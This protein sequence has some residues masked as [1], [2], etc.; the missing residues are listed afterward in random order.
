MA[1]PPI[2][3]AQPLCLLA[4]DEVHVWRVALTAPAA[5]A[6]ALGHLLTPA[7]QARA[8]RF[9][10]EDDRCRFQ[11]ARAATRSILGA[12]L[13][14]PPQQVGIDLEPSGKPRLDA[15]SVPIERRVHFNISHSGSWILAAFATAFPVGID[16]EQVRAERVTEDLIG[17]I[18]SDS[19]QR[20][21][22]GLAPQ[23]RV[24]A[25]FNCWTSKEALLKG[26]GVGLSA[27]LRAIEVSID[28]HL[29][30]RLIDAPPEHG[31][32]EWQLGRVEIG[33]PYAATLAF[34]A[35]SA[36]IVNMSAVLPDRQR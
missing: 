2:R 18:M 12:Y 30:P 1:T 5:Q 14:L 21:L 33:G 10:I 7:E 22:Q 9:R 19:E 36:R 15:S 16:V 29:P 3:S 26:I 8:S 35:Q 6:R 23:Q 31:P 20:M 13:G 34:R 28:P 4:G 17:H 32:G 24:A 27:S 25:F 11:I